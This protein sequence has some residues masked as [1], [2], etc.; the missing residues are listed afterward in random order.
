MRLTNLKL[1]LG[2]NT[3]TNVING[4]NIYHGNYNLQLCN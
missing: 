2:N 3:Y 1:Q 4:Q